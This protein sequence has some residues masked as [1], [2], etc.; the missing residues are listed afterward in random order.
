V[1]RYIVMSESRSIAA[2][3]YRALAEFRYPIQ[4]FL[5]FSEQATR[6]AGLEP[7]QHQMLLALK[8]LSEGTSP[9]IA[10][11]A[12]R[13][14]IRHHSA[15]ELADRLARRGYITRRRNKNDRREVWLALTEKSERVLRSLS[16]DHKAE[17][18]S[19]GPALAAALERLISEQ[20]HEGSTNG[21]K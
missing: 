2:S 16:L 9:R 3:E 4:R 10:E 17:L 21:R 19:N 7:V 5:H 8:G 13:L 11:L 18:R 15:V 20:A 14:Q 12:A 1:L 6:S